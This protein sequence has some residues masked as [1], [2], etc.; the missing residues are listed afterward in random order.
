MYCQSLRN[1][2]SHSYFVSVFVFLY[3]CLYLYL[4]LCFYNLFTC[5]WSNPDAHLS[6]MFSFNFLSSSKFF[7][8][9]FNASDKIFGKVAPLIR[10]S[11][12]VWLAGLMSSHCICYFVF[13]IF[14]LKISFKCVSTKPLEDKFWK[15][16]K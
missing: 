5:Q 13:V 3:L 4:Y 6:E 8:T 9:S 12:Q 16:S 10:N 14:H 7:R 1:V 11:F 15:C 2:V